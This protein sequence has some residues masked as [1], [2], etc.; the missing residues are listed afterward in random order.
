LKKES[1]VWYRRIDEYLISFG[2]NRSPSEP[3]LYTKVNQEGKILIVCLYV[4]DLIFT[5]DIFVDDFKNA[6][7][8]EFEMTDLGLMKYF[9]GIEVDQSDDGFFICQTNYANEV[10]KR[11]RML[12]CKPT[13][14]PMA[15]GIKLSKYTIC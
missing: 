4:D 11:F 1:R 14:T 3:T 8:A 5:R 15:T 10:L 2:F 6:M 9:I 13:A 12:N 7:K